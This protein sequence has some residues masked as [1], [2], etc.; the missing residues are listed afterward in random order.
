MSLIAFSFS[1]NLCVTLVQTALLAYFVMCF[2]IWFFEEIELAR[3][4]ISA[5]IK[6]VVML[7]SNLE[8]LRTNTYVVQIKMFSALLVRALRG[9]SCY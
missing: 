3:L 9:W 8:M 4:Y 6:E 1:N 5:M 2:N 7:I